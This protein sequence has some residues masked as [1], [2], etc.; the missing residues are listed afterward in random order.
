MERVESTP[1]M[2][3]NPLGPFLVGVFVACAIGVAVLSTKYYFSV[4]QLTRLN[5]Q[6]AMMN[7]ARNA[8]QN[9]A[10]EALEY[11]RR[12]PAIDPLLEKF[13][14]KG[15]GTNAAGMT[16]PPAPVAPK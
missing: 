9:M 2:K 8:A 16:N 1:D 7:N 3:A 10:G 6:A 5:I 14:I 12:N 15:K 13:D 4:K 11:S